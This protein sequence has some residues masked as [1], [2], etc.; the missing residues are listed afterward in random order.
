MSF[1]MCHW[2]DCASMRRHGR[3]FGSHPVLLLSSMVVRNRNL[4]CTQPALHI[5]PSPVHQKLH[6]LSLLSNQQATHHHRLTS[7]QHSNTTTFPRAP[8]LHTI[9]PPIQASSHQQSYASEPVSTPN[10]PSISPKTTTNTRGNGTPRNN[11]LSIAR[12]A[13]YYLPIFAKMRFRVSKSNGCLTLRQTGLN[14]SESCRLSRIV[15]SSLFRA[16]SSVAG[17]TAK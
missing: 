4:D 1:P 17:T 16:L 3:R 9:N 12:L 5:T 13:S 11:Y 10:S 14:L 2:C 6:Q 15:M 7:Q 8:I